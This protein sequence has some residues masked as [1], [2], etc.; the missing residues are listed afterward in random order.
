MRLHYEGF[1]DVHRNATICGPVRLKPG[2]TTYIFVLFRLDYK[3]S[4][5]Y[6]KGL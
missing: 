5:P 2:V 4:I 6:M 1:K 3:M